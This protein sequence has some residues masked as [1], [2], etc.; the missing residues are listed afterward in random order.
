MSDF[1]SDTL[2]TESR[3]AGKWQIPTFL[4]SAILLAVTAL[5]VPSPQRKVG[6]KLN[7]ER[8]VRLLDVGRFDAAAKLANELLEWGELE[9]AT[10]GL[11]HLQ[12]ARAA[13]GR[14]ERVADDSP[15]A[16][17]AV[18]DEYEKALS[19]RQALTEGDDYR[20]AIS[21]ERLGQ[22]SLALKYHQLAADAALPPALAHRR[23]VIEISEYPLKKPS[24]EIAALLDH[25]MEDAKDQ[26]A[27]LIWA[28]SQRIEQMSGAEHLKEAD[29]LLAEYAPSFAGGAYVSDYAYLRALA[30]WRA[31]RYDDAEANLRAVLNELTSSHPVY[32]RAAW[33]LGRVVMNDGREQRPEEAI[34]IF[35]EVIASR[36][37]AL[38]VAASR[39]GLAEA[40]AE[41]FRF[42]ESVGAYRDAIDD[43]GRLKIQPLVN[44][45]VI[46]SSLTV[47]AEQA[48]Q[49]GRLKDSIGFMQLA[50]SLVDAGDYERLS[51]YLL[52]LGD[53]KASSARVMRSA[54]QELGDE[55]AKERSDMLENARILLDDAGEDFVKVAW[56]STLNE[57]RSAGAM[58][59]AA[60]LFDESGNHRRTIELLQAFVRDRPDAEI[61]P[62]VLLRL[63]Q[64]LQAEGRYADAIDA[65]QRD[66]S[67]YPRSPHAN[68]A[69]IPL[70]RCYMA[71]GED[72][73][74]E[75]ENALRRIID[76]S[77][78]FTPDAVEY[79]DA[80]FLLG[81]LHT[82][83]GRYE[84]A[85]P[86]LEEVLS[87]HPD[88]TRAAWAT[89]LIADAFRKSAMAIKEEL[90]KP[91]FVGESKRMRADFASRM[92]EAARRFRELIE[93]LKVDEERLAGLDALYLRD[94]RLYEAAC[95][96]E[97]KRYR[98]ALALYERAAWIYKDS[99]A[100][101]GAYVQVINCYIFLG[102]DEDAETSLR[103]AQYLVETIDEALFQADGKFESRADWRRYFDWVSEILIKQKETGLASGNP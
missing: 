62:R 2:G 100:A 60:G 77:E 27:E 58:W 26:P 45:D 34:A 101:L 15:E 83:Q 82:R 67:S 97:L 41:V 57:T 31:E 75:A 22:F 46:R 86:V 66:I 99:P 24:E 80:M 50:V 47:V 88:D 65:Y 72:K 35:R 71:L 52:R 79:R 13:F 48:Q 84:E 70:A 30:D 1:S 18:I 68:A 33:L 21:H 6:F 43:L 8:V 56:M 37:E 40:L 59:K 14:M 98:E 90:L 29:T 92:D 55:A 39:I 91:E 23:R 53:L 17:R 63:G 54:A 9:D 102:R 38:Y 78:F 81:D 51:K 96:F 5:S 7:L 4:L 49:R 76:D 95:L 89:F 19:L 87:Q 64:S 11:L 25:Y 61:I 3:F 20:I 94:A 103:R 74:V 44:P 10:V 12:L 85:I 93:R 32:S 36:G 28:L 42:E 16:A 69:L 73:E